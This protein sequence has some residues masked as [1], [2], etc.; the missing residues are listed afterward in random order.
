MIF[1]DDSSLRHQALHLSSLI[2]NCMTSFPGHE[3]IQ[4]PACGILW[5]LTVGHMA[6]D[7]AVE[8]VAMAGAI[9]PICQAMRDLPCNM[10][11]Q[12][13]AIGALTSLCDTAGRAAIC[14]RLN[15][16]QAIIA[17]LKKHAAVG[18]IA[19]LGCIILCMFCDDQQLKHSIVQL[20]ALQIAKALSRTENSE[21][22]QWGCE[23]LRDLSDS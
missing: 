20:G 16:I 21:A 19:G 12:Q 5:R 15:G 7:E 1:L 18:H 11:L 6:R 14:A 4:V 9:N 3:Q 2:V 22:Q 8:R 10:D 13:L 23:L 17:A